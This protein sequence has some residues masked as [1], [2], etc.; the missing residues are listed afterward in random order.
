[1]R[2]GIDLM[3][4]DQ[5]PEAIFSAVLRCRRDIDPAISLVV[6]ARDCPKH[7]TDSLL[8][9]IPTEE[10]IEMGETPLYAVRKKKKASMAVGVRLVKEG[11]LDALVSTGNTGALVALSTMH[12]PLLPTIQKPALLAVLPTEL[13]VIAVLDVGAHIHYKST[14]FLDYAK[15]GVLYQEC[16]RGITNP[17]VGLLNIGSEEKK[18]TCEVKEAYRTLQEYFQHCEGQ[19]V[20]NVEGREVFQG[21]V[22]VMVTDG[23]TGNVFLKTCEG[24]SSFLFEYLGKY[25]ARHATGDCGA[26][27][28]GHFH[29]KFNYA[30]QPG[31]FLCGVE[32]V[33]VKCHGNSDTQAMISGI[34]G[35]VALVEKQVV[36]KMKERLL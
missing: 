20:G 15:L 5:S 17:K 22:D 19:F 36:K 35:A 27:L 3:G 30:N 2:I 9:F 4:G 11:K 26:A 12:L 13:G 25:F 29:E 24:A 6:L 28:L 10:V 14:H 16:F 23:F 33:I 21:K 1:V 7:S 18:G 32:G 34:R 8:E 31:A